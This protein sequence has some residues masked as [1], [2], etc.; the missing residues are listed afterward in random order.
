MPSTLLD[1]R[2]ALVIID[3]QRGVVGMPTVPHTSEVVAKNSA[4]LARAFRDQDLPVVLVRVSFSADGADVAPGRITDPM[5]KNVTFPEG[6]DELI[7]DLD[8]QPTDIRIT[9]R[10]W[11]AFHGTEL[12][13]QLRRRG[14]T[15]IVLTGIATSIGVESTARAAHEHGY[16]VVVVE[17]ATADRDHASH[18]H[19]TTKIFPRLGLVATTDQILK[20]LETR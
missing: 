17:D 5:P 10:Q 11:G 6:W 2:T 14:I 1:P 7:D 16:N 15:E 20:E 13:L 19:T 3:L 18:D 8:V 9:K 12:D 4:A